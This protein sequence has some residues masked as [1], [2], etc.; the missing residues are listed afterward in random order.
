MR[1]GGDRGD[2]GGERGPPKCYKCQGMGHISKNCPQ[3]DG[4]NQS[5]RRPNQDT[6]SSKPM[7]P[8]DKMSE[9]DD[10]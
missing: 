10:Y 1:G 5:Q 9:D 8:A 6:R 2:R 4:D 3:G 7:R